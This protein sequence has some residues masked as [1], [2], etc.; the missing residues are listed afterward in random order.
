[1][2]TPTSS[3]TRRL[4]WK[5]E[6]RQRHVQE[7]SQIKDNY[8]LRRD[9]DLDQPVTVDILKQWTE[10][11]KQQF[12]EAAKQKIFGM[13]GI[14]D[15][16]NAVFTLLESAAMY[17]RDVAAVESAIVEAKAGNT[18]QAI[19]YLESADDAI[20]EIASF[21]GFEYTTICDLIESTPDGHFLIVGPFCGALAPVNQEDPF[22]GIAF[23]GTSTLQ[24]WA[25]NIDRVPQATGDSSILWGTDVSSGVFNC[26]FGTYGDWGIPMDHILGYIETFRSLLPANSSEL[27]VH[28]TGHSLGASYATLCYGQLLQYQST[29]PTGWILGDLYTFGSPRIG[30]NSFASQVRNAGEHAPGSAWRIVNQDDSVTALPPAPAKLFLGLPLEDDARIYIH[31][32]SA[33]RISITSPPVVIPSEIGMDPGPA[34][35]AVDELIEVGHMAEHSPS[36]YFASLLIAN[37]ID[38]L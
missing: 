25:T 24:E 6:L 32:D 17:L 8:K 29:T 3:E 36:F 28:V 35:K 23:K 5:K 15:W 37:G 4:G 26:L 31:V 33:Y 10:Q 18:A 12:D 14:I 22:L 16:R 7:L 30:M 34:P 27:A 1:M 20:N 9:G 13:K 2:S 38:P 21:W 11:V 19:E